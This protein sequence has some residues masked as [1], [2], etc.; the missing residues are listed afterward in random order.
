MKH[1]PSFDEFLNEAKQ[2]AFK[3][4]LSYYKTDP[5]A[6]KS[7]VIWIKASDKDAAIEAAGDF[8]ELDTAVRLKTKV[9]PVSITGDLE[10]NFKKY[11]KECD[12]KRGEPFYNA[13]FA[14]D[15]K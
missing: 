1:I 14:E 6:N 11:S 4:E 5:G 8:T 15:A 7:Q 3:V 2:T 12:I 9:E 13:V 10:S